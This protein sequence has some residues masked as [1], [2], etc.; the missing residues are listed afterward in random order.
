MSDECIFCAIAAGR[1][2]TELIASN[3]HA[4]VFADLSPQAPVHLL[5]IPREHIDNA[6]ALT[7]SHE[8]VLAAVFAAA[9]SAARTKGLSPAGG[10]GGYRL[11]FNVGPDSG[12][13]VPHLHLHVI[14]GRE[15][16]WPPG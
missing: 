8:E 14:G 3:D 9:R 15:L 6:D 5:A 1:T 2:D 10:G 4:I 7:E 16:A 11:V 12:N 13:A